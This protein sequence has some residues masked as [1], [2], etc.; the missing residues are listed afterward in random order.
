MNNGD[1]IATLVPILIS[2]IALVA[3]MASLLLQIRQL[4]TSQAEVFRT[5]QVE[6]ARMAFESPEIIVDPTDPVRADPIMF[7]THIYLNLMVMYWRAAFLLGNMNEAGLRHAVATL[8]TV[9][10]RCDWWAM[11]RASYELMSGFRGSR[12]RR[13][14]DAVEAEFQRAIAGFT[15]NPEPSPSASHE[16]Q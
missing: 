13:F 16:R 4:R 9:R 8:F 2:S 6:I 5:L 10:S 7:R 15:S 11:A 1:A 3:V 14:F 12:S